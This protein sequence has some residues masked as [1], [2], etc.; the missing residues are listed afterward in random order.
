MAQRR[1]FAISVVET[2]EFY[3]LP[4]TAQA[5]YLHFSMNA[6]DEGFVSKPK[7]ILRTVGSSN[8]DYQALIDSGFLLLFDSGKVVVTHWFQSN[9]IRKDRGKPTELIKERSQIYI[10]ESGEYAFKSADLPATE[11][12]VNQ[13][14]TNCQPSGNQTTPQYSIGKYS[15]DKDSIV[16]DSIDKFSIEE[17]SQVSFDAN[18]SLNFEKLWQMHPKGDKK[19]AES[20]FNKLNLDNDGLKKLFETL[21]YQKRTG[22]NE[23][24]YSLDTWLN[25][26]R[27]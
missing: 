20:R 15:T 19:N 22:A 4:L 2:D 26:Y 18:F 9:Q 6:D 13:V 16:Q 3:E 7:A 21:E 5:L 1:M 25:F 12:N 27:C 24:A 17:S 23:T 8:E 11:T 10:T 14:A